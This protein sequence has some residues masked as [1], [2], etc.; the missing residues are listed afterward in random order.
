MFSIWATKQVSGFNG[1]NHLL[2]HI[3][4][5]TIDE[6][7]NCGCPHPWFIEQMTCSISLLFGREDNFLWPR[8]L[9]CVRGKERLLPMIV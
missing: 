8:L 5:S 1:N 4:G 6:C 7:P 9:L 3:N 2:R